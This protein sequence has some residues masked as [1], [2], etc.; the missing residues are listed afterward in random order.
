M[1]VGS[2]A[3]LTH[4]H[5]RVSNVEHALFLI[6]QACVVDFLLYCQRNMRGR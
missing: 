2:K 4:N 6:F 5:V 1:W 3:G